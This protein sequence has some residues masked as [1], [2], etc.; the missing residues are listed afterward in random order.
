MTEADDIARRAREIGER[1]QRIAEDSTDTDALREELDRLDAELAQLDEE[2]RRLDEEL[3]DRGEG[4]TTV[5][6]EDEPDRPQW[7]ETVFDLVSDVTE[8]ISS[9]GSG[10]WPWRSSETTERT[11]PLAD[12]TAVVVDNR[13]GS[14]KVTSGDS[15]AVHVSAELF[16][17]SP[18]HLEEMTVTAERLGSE[19]H[20]R[21]DW[22]N[23]RHGR[24]ARVLVSV[25]SGT[26]VRANTLGGA[27]SI[28]QTHGPARAGT[29]GGSITIVGASGD[30]EARTAGGSIRVDDHTGPVHATTS[31]GS[32]HLSGVLTGE[33]EAK[34]A[35]GSVH[36]EGAERATVNATT[37]GGS[38]HVRG[39]L[40]GHNHIR[41]AGGSVT[42]SIPSD[43]QVHIDGK[44]TNASS[45]FGDLTIDRGRIRGTLGDGSEGTIEFRTSAGAVTLGKT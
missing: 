44:G 32:I 22:P 7:A 45:D 12:A 8:R 6:D 10:G 28:K 40:A 31:G 24:R 26:P 3:R 18:H 13:A 9:L 4:N 30:V 29:K 17:P 33:V 39:R 2:Q 34:T 42:V 5:L 19:I 14:I 20:V 35:G 21:C 38:V 27:I 16:A 11:V 25:P 43:S 23:H 1:A 36:I 37:S 41:T 15:D